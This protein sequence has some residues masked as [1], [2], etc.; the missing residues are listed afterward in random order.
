MSA[1]LCCL[2]GGEG[3]SQSGE[4]DRFDE[5]L[6]E[7]RSR[8]GESVGLAGPPRQRDEHGAGADLSP[9]LPGHIVAAHVGEPKIEQDHV[10]GALAGLL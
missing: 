5:V 3:A 1:R 6:V 7:A 2:Q 8:R 10:K 4:S 9:N